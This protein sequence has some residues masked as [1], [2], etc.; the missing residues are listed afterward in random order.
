MRRS[1]FPLYILLAV[2]LA[3]P[4]LYGQQPAPRRH[5]RVRRRPQPD[6]AG[7]AAGRCDRPRCSPMDA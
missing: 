4:A 7:A 3:A 2:V 1:M 5:R 6:A